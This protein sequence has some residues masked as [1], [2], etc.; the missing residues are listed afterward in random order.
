LKYTIETEMIR[1]I[2]PKNTRHYDGL[3]YFVK[4]MKYMNLKKICRKYFGMNMFNWL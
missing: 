3:S 4:L 2:K 1:N